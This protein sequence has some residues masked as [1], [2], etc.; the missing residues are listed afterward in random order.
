MLGSVHVRGGVS[1]GTWRQSG[2]I[3]GDFVA[4]LLVRPLQAPDERGC[5]PSGINAEAL[6]LA[7]SV[8][9]G[10]SMGAA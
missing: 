10:R 9:T 6:S 5:Q 3:A 1:R 4:A 8:G 7:V 2:G